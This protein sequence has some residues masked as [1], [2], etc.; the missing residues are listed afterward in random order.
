MLSRLH[1]TWFGIFL[2]SSANRK[3][4]VVAKKTVTG[5]AAR[6]TNIAS[7]LEFADLRLH[8]QRIDH[9]SLNN[10]SFDHSSLN[11][12]SQV[13]HWMGAMQAQ[14][15]GQALWAVALRTPAATQAEVEQAILERSIVVTWLMRGTIHLVAATDL[16]WMLNLCAPRKLAAAGSRLKQLELD[17]NILGRCQHLFQTALGGG[18]C[19][20]RSALLELLET[21]GIDPK[22]QRGYHILWYLAQMGLI[23]FGPKH[24]KEQ[25]FVLLEEWIPSVPHISREVALAKLAQR[26]FTS[27]GPATVQDFAIWTGLTLGEA[28]AGLEAVQGQLVSEKVD[29]LEY[30]W[31]D[32]ALEIPL[33]QGTG[34]HLLPGF[35][36]Y[37]LGYK[38]RRDVITVEHAKRIVPGGNGVFLPMIVVDGQVVGTWKRQVK[39]HGVNISLELFLEPF[40]E[41]FLE[42]G[43]FEEGVHGA[44]MRYCTFMGLPLLAQEILKF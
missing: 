10:S 7:R 19:L 16:R 35:D 2:Y 5:G 13:V 6:A 39:K 29:G 3:E 15:Y 1:W 14:D 40:L 21:A 27:H 18:Q 4:R 32:T 23:C 44:V 26:Y 11:N 30:W 22:G 37:L 17:V 41:P 24:G 33:E 25:T 34:V 43:A 9:S 20:T 12:S 38:D 28:R 42:S 36:E 8:H 31:A